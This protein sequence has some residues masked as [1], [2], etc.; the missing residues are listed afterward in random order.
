MRHLAHRN[1][2]TQPVRLDA[3]DDSSL[4]VGVQL[5][6]WR[7]TALGASVPAVVAHHA[8]ALR[9]VTHSLLTRA[10][11]SSG[12]VR[13][14]RQPVPPARLE[15]GDRVRALRLVRG[16]T[17]EDLAEAASIHRT[18]LAGVETGQRNPTLEVIHKLARGLAVAPEDLFRSHP[19]VLAQVDSEEHD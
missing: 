7:A 10:L 17:Q 16:M 15:F 6:L 18:Y 5:A 4:F 2:S 8:P 12:L 19:S 1:C 3:Q 11:S 13:V 14:P 9:P